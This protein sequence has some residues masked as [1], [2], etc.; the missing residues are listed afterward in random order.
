MSLEWYALIK[1]PITYKQYSL[2]LSTPYMN[3]KRK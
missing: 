2:S 3:H 1:N